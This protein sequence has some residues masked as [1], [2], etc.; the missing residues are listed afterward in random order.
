[1]SRHQ[2]LETDQVET[3]QV[4]GL[5]DEYNRNRLF[6]RARSEGRFYENLACIALIIG[7]ELDIMKTSESI[8]IELIFRKKIS[9]LC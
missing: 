4:S 2:Y 7:L 6:M 3:D 9:V 1:M 5:S 8:Y